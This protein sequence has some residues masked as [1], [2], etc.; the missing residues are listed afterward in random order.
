MVGAKVESLGQGLIQQL[1]Q[2]Y[3]AMA[4]L[5][6]GHLVTLKGTFP[7]LDLAQGTILLGAN[8]Q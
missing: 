2:L 3:S 1:F 7:A 4:H 5:P 8:A 6:Q